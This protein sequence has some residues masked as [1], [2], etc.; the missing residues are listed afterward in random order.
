MSVAGTQGSG[1]ASMMVTGT[2][3]SA[4]RDS[5]TCSPPPDAKSSK[6]APEF[7]RSRS[8]RSA[9]ALSNAD[10]P[11]EWLATYRIQCSATRRSPRTR[12]S[13][14]APASALTRPGVRQGLRLNAGSRRTRDV[15]MSGRSSVRSKAMIEPPL[16]P[17]RTAG[18]ARSAS[19]SAI[20]S[21]RCAR[22]SRGALHR[23]QACP[24]HNHNPRAHR[25]ET[26]RAAATPR[27]EFTPPPP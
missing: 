20:A 11:V 9:G 22:Q 14:C 13:S 7:C 12:R 24:R 15:T 27:A 21:S 2:S 18:A 16:Y 23:V 17:T 5:S 10:P 4:S 19:I 1:P 8:R 26:R 3:M 25:D 6:M